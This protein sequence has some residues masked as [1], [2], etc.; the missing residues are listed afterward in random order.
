MGR[1]K[2]LKRKKATEGNSQTG[3]CR[4]ASQST[5]INERARGS[6][7]HVL[8]GQLRIRKESER[9]SERHS[10]TEEGTWKH[11]SGQEKKEASK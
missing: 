6:D 9:A 11:K 3:E 8:E 5:K 7:T 10:R 4:V 2:S 1:N